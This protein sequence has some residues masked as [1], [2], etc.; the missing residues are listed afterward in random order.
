MFRL[1]PCLLAL[2][3]LGDALYADGDDSRE[4]RVVVIAKSEQDGPGDRDA[5]LRE[6]RR[7]LEKVNREL[8]EI[9]ATMQGRHPEHDRAAKRERHARPQPPAPRRPH[10]P[11]PQLRRPIEVEV[12]VEVCSECEADCKCG[13]HPKAQVKR[14]VLAHKGGD[15]IM[16]LEG[17][18]DPQQARKFIKQGPGLAMGFG[19]PGVGGVTPPRK[20][21]E[22]HAKLKALKAKQA[23]YAA[24]AKEALASNDYE[25]AAKAAHLA[26]STGK[27]IAAAEKVVAAQAKLART[28]FGP[29]GVG[30]HP[31]EARLAKVEQ[32][33]DRIEGL[34]KKLL[35]EKKKRGR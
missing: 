8:A 18:L 2:F 28:S 31:M 5:K 24:K 22:M 14:R 26:A 23:G 10:L 20:A 6:L 3:V 4:R 17:G 12:E 33:L 15:R 34:L 9:R 30:P 16:V 1:I 27:A 25:G 35:A 32:R 19:G 13:P 7:R 29:A 11:P 21:Q